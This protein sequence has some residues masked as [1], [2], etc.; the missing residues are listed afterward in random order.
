MRHHIGDSFSPFAYEIKSGKRIDDFSLTNVDCCD[1]C[2]SE[3]SKSDIIIVIINH[4]FFLKSIDNRWINSKKMQSRARMNGSRAV[5][6][7]EWLVWIVLWSDK[8][9]IVVVFM[10]HSC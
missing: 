9:F 8:N 3:I 7:M 2:I 1:Y 6:L 5:L 10:V 4:R